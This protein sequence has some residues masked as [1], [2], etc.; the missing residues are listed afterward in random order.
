MRLFSKLNKTIFGYFD[1]EKI[2]LDNE[3]NDLRGD[4]TDMSAK[5]GPL[6]AAAPDACE[7]SA[8]TRA[9]VQSV[10][11]VTEGAEGPCQPRVARHE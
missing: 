3:T 11:G 1:P 2:F 10:G 7:Q 9:S 4:L 6:S 8:A 5:K